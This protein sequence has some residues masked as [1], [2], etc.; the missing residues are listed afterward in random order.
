MQRLRLTIRLYKLLLV[1][2]KS[3]QV[4]SKAY[5]QII[6][7]RRVDRLLLTQQ[8][9]TIGIA[10]SNA[11]A[12]INTTTFQIT[13]ISRKTQL[14]LQLVLI[15]SKLSNISLEVDVRLTQRL[16]L[17]ISDSYVTS[18]VVIGLY[19]IYVLLSKRLN[20][21]VSN[22]IGLSLRAINIGLN[23]FFLKARF[24]IKLL[25]LVSISKVV[26]YNV[27]NITKYSLKVFLNSV[28]ELGSRLYISK[29]L[30]FTIRVDIKKID[31][32]SVSLIIITNIKDYLAT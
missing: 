2:E 23:S 26:V 25:K 29:N 28:I 20:F 17:L 6:R 1:K 12:N 10:A 11:A 4:I 15:I 30:F 22:R 18:V 8:A 3:Q 19:Y 32:D 13:T 21:N 7:Q 14:L 27:N 31:K 9:I 5:K 16:K 24:I